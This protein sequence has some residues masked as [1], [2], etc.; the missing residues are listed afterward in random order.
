MINQRQSLVVSRSSMRI[1]KVDYCSTSSCKVALPPRS[2]IIPDEWIADGF[3][4]RNSD[5]FI[6]RSA[7][8]T[9][10]RSYTHK[11]EHRAG[12]ATHGIWY[13]RAWWTMCLPLPQACHQGHEVLAGHR[14]R[15]TE[16]VVR[17]AALGYDTGKVETILL[18]STVQSSCCTH[19][20]SFGWYSKM[21]SRASTPG[22]SMCFHLSFYNS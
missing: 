21:I 10:S 6:L 14:N 13:R 20:M 4:T 7:A 16:R 1:W 15:S 22:Q 18:Y 12:C 2:T 9:V 11:T 17:T 19:S 5:L 3:K 8:R